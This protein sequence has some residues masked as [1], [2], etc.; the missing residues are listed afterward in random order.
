MKPAECH[1]SK[2]R[3][4]LFG[5]DQWITSGP[6]A[7]TAGWIEG[8]TVAIEYRWAEGRSERFAEFGSRV[9]SAES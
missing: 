8:R 1:A 2:E 4:L 7:T 6:A 5:T 9:R 3:V